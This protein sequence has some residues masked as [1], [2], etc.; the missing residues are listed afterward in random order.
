MKKI[1]TASLLSFLGFANAQISPVTYSVPGTF[2]FTVPPSVSSITIET[3][4]AGGKGINNGGGGG[5]GGGYALGVYAVS[6]G[7]VLSVKVGSPNVNASVGTSSVGI[8]TSTLIYATGGTNGFSASTNT[9]IGGSGTGGAGFLGTISNFSGGAGG[10]GCWTYFGAGGGGAAGPSGNGGNGGNTPVYNGTNC[11]T[12][13]GIGGTGSGAPAG[14]GGAGAGFSNSLCSVSIPATN[15]TSFG[16]GGGSGNGI[17]SPATNGSSGYVRIS[18]GTSTCTPP[19]APTPSASV[20][21]ICAGNSANLVAFTTGTT[22]ATIN[23]Y[24]VATG[25][26]ILAS[27]ISYNTGTLSIGTYTYYAGALTCTNSITRTPI[28][29]NVSGPPTITANFNPPTM[30]AGQISTLSLSGA[31]FY[32]VT[33]LAI[34]PSYTV[35]PSA[36]TI[37]TIVGTSSIGCTSTVFATLPITPSP[38]LNVTASPSIICSGQSSTLSATGGASYTWT[39]TI[40]MT[41]IVSPTTTTTYTASTSNSLGCTSTK[42]VTI[43][44][45]TTPTVSISASSTLICAGQSATLTPSGA[46]VYSWT[47]AVPLTGI[48]TPSF[49]TTYTA[50]GTGTFGCTGQSAI[51]I[52]VQICSGIAV[53]SS[54][55]QNPTFQLFPN[56]INNELNIVTND[57]HMNAYVYNII[58]EVLMEIQL[59]EKHTKLNVANLP[60]GIYILQVNKTA[61]RFLK[62]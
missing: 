17:G 52:S 20:V 29:V 19:P 47:P 30:C 4:G 57:E 60:K 51:T 42:T 12:P 14:N 56:P 34:P 16:G 41:G 35:S 32:S 26:T 55:N 23:W 54:N 58:G 45:S 9:V 1:F 53:S 8:G 44:A 59:K 48:V 11:N 28:I 6:S 21:N 62:D 22:I 27:G 7:T 18:W 46:L 36:T 39:P 13:G 2:S 40:P 15:P 50:I 49:T 31:S 10:N 5:G 61:K 38:T 3:I 43:F 24:N 33:P 25:G 37:Y